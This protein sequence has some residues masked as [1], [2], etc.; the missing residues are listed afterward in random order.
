SAVAGTQMRVL[1]GLIGFAIVS[2]VWEKGR[3]LKSALSHKS[4]M[5]LTFGG[6]IFGPFLGVTLSLF[7][8]QQTKAGIASAIMGLNPVIIIIP[9]VIFFKQKVR[10][11]EVAGA[12]VAVAGTMVLFL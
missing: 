9:L 3:N 12:V 5:G 10:L 11:L 2:L 7:A 8:V 6:S 4:G 1:V